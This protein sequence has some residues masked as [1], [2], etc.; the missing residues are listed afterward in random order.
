LAPDT[1]T[2]KLQAAAGIARTDWLK[3]WLLKQLPLLGDSPAEWEAWHAR[4]MKE[5]HDRDKTELLQQADRVSE[6]TRAIKALYGKDHP[7]VK[8]RH[9]GFS[10]ETW[11]EI[12][13]LRKQAREQRGMQFIQ[14]PQAIADKA[15]SLLVDPRF[16]DDFAAIAAG[17]CFATGRRHTETMSTAVFAPVPGSDW[18][19]LF[20]GQLKKRDD[21]GRD[22]LTFEIPTLVPAAEVLA[23]WHRLRSLCPEAVGMDHTLVHRT[24]KDAV[25]D[26][27]N[28]HF[29]GLAPPRSGKA[30]LYT[31]ISRVVYGAISTHWF[32]P[33]E[34]PPAD[35]RDFI[36]GHFSIES[37]ADG[38]PYVAIIGIST[39]SYQDYAIADASGRNTDGRTG[40]RLGQPGVVPIEYARDRLAAIHR[41]QLSIS[42]SLPVPQPAN[43]R[44]TSTLVPPFERLRN[45]LDVPAGN[46]RLAFESIFALAAAAL[47]CLPE[48]T[49]PKGMDADA[50]ALA[51]PSAAPSTEAGD[52]GD[53]DTDLAELAELLGLDTADY[54]AVAAALS[55]FLERDA[56]RREQLVTLEGQLR[57]SRDFANS[58][59]QALATIALALDLDPS[60]T[61]EQVLAA[62]SRL[63]ETATHP[64]TPPA[65][66][67]TAEFDR[68]N[69]L[70]DRRFHEFQ[71]RL[72]D[73]GDRLE[74]LEADNG[75][76]IAFID[77]M[78]AAMGSAIHSTPTTAMPERPPTTAATT[79][80]TAATTPTAAPKRRQ[81]GTF[82]SMSDVRALV[83][84]IMA[85]NEQPGHEGDRFFIA[86]NMLRSLIFAP[87][88]D[89]YDFLLGDDMAP[90][91][92]RHHQQFDLNHTA[93]RGKSYAPLKA[94]IL[95][96]KPE[97]KDLPWKNL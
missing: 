32:C 3:K 8:N 70:L 20:T 85:F 26:A 39:R 2:D 14:N 15:R 97:L 87:K 44:L 71:E 48:G 4:L 81:S 17:L 42:E 83:E 66:N 9:V 37:D 54:D 43:I 28:T 50:L 53:D 86:T 10:Q 36:Q 59:S 77:T 47:A 56:V 49:D 62:I 65:S 38:S 19:V 30:D 33:P 29:Q 24:Y 94:W 5:L 78:M 75:P 61:G 52:V 79:A 96:H 92:E 90:L 22:P 80:V 57:Q 73:L 7:A 45:L 40:I 76:R 74:T 51:F 13:R 68:I 63:R 31:L 93:N 72:H 6:A 34:I 23:A 67:L 58:R 82:A 46:N 69:G 84:A 64:A 18:S 41:L 11:I 1:A 89:T 91:L 25:A 21:G 60:A 35:F 27:C 12:D 55:E 16:H 95:E 88:N